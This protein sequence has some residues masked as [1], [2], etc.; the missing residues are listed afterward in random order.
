MNILNDFG[1]ER[2]Y[3]EE[4]SVQNQ[5]RLFSN[6]DKIIGPHGAGLTNMVWGDEMTV[7]EIHNDHVRDHYYV[8]ANNLG[9]DYIA[10]QGDSTY[11]NQLNSNIIVDVDQIE[12]TLANTIRR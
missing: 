8:L 12:V 9:H 7:F 1:F 2:V 5:I 4:L 10:I 6:A 11:S 3:A